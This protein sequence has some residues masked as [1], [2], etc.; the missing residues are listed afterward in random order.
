M[1]L[2]IRDTKYGDTRNRV[3]GPEFSRAM[4]FGTSADDARFASVADIV[5]F[6]FGS[7]DQWLEEDTPIYVHP[8]DPYK[9]VDL[10]TSRRKIRIE[11]KG[12]ILAEAPYCIL[13]LETGL[14]TRYYMPY[15]AVKQASANLLKSE[16]VT[17]CPYKGIAGY[18]NA[19][20]VPQGQEFPELFTDLVWY[21]R[22][23]TLECAA[24]AGMICF[25]N[26]KV[27]IYLDEKLLGE[28]KVFI[29]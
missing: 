12:Q 6:E 7:M 2:R 27:D 14:P 23:P 17:E 16:R 29:I 28:S 19:L 11:Y 18:Y 5:R 22:H 10:L 3:L 13:L 26:E 20:I 21:Y 9:R 24:I 4:R 15:T 1:K 25:Y 8:K